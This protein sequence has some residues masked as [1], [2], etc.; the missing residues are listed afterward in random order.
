MTTQE[1]IKSADKLAKDT[2][3]NQKARVTSP[4]A[5]TI[6]TADQLAYLERKRNGNR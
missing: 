6:N 4:S 1:Q 2:K 5:G 3:Q